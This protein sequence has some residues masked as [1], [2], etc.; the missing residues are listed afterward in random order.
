MNDK[1]SENETSASR[2]TIHSVTRKCYKLFLKLMKKRRE[3]S[4]LQSRN[5]WIKLEKGNK[6]VNIFC[7][8]NECTK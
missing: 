4:K 5:R 1:K 2:S 8:T 3:N 7:K 6:L